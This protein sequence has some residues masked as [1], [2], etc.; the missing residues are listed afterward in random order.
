MI[1]R[2]TEVLATMFLSQGQTG[3]QHTKSKSKKKDNTQQQSSQ[4]SFAEI[5][6]KELKRQ[7]NNNR[8]K[9]REVQ[10]Y[11]DNKRTDD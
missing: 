1:D 10:S 2:V 5:L 8:K 11:D 4:K 6:D 3:T 9:Q 7:Y